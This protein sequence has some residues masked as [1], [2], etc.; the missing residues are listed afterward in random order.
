MIRDVDAFIAHLKHTGRLKLLPRVLKELQEESTR[1]RL[2]GARTET[3]KENP[4]LISG[5]RS[6]KDGVLT[7]TTGKRALLEIYKKITNV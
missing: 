5:S 7:D 1:E 6:I 3:A 2:S 4:A